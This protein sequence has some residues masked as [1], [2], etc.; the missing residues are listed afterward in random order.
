MNSDKKTPT[1]DS[2]PIKISTKNLSKQIFESA[3]PEQFT[4]Q[5]PTQIL[6]SSIREQGVLSS[7]E[8]IELASKEQLQHL[9]D[10]DIW[11]RDTLDEERIWQ[12]LELPEATNDL[13][14]LQKIL[15][16]IDLKIIALLITRHVTVFISEESTD[17]PPDKF[18]SSPDTGQSWIKVSHPDER[19][20]FLLKRLLALIFETNFKIYYQL[21]SIPDSTTQSVLEEEG[22]SEKSKRLMAEG[23]PSDT[24]AAEIQLGA[25]LHQ[26]LKKIHFK[27]DIKVSSEQKSENS[28]TAPLKYQSADL[29]SPLK[30]LIHT[31]G[32][33]NT[34]QEELALL[35]NSAAVHFH[36][37]WWHHEEILFLN[38]Q[39]IGALNLGL[40]LITGSAQNKN[41][42][43]GITREESLL[44][45]YDQISLTGIYKAGIF[46]LHHL[47]NSAKHLSDETC[48]SDPR[49]LTVLEQLQAHFPSLPDFIKSDG[50]IK[51]DPQHSDR[52][53]T[54]KKAISN[55]KQLEIAKMFITKLSNN[56]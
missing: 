1:T 21:L 17:Q 36:L 25:P 18:F 53:A 35:S 4:R 42:L 40:Q 29:P 24:W 7:A 39:I 6:Y 22:Y 37:P 54:T 31:V 34:L 56:S 9:L 28:A 27:Q 43:D 46:P 32:F 5:I 44:Q 26:I 41:D 10:F 48:Q 45:I 8:I 16:S 30:E 2:T 19:K 38:E 15:G 55:T 51:T 3:N 50:T 23:I 13:K 11:T 47:R 33:T 20:Q 49:L 52:L 14:I 12:W